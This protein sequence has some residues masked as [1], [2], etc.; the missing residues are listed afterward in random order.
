MH[1]SLHP[2][3]ISVLKRKTTINLTKFISFEV[4]TYFE[5]QFLKGGVQ[6]TIKCP[7]CNEYEFHEENDFDIC[8]MCNWENDGI[9]YDDPDYA[10]GAN[11]ESLNEYR[12]NWKLQMIR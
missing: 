1:G 6:L 12:N 5:R 7:V 10:G 11:K 9:Q 3:I 4:T 8:D 2:V